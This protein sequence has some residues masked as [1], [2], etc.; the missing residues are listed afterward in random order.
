[1]SFGP[2]PS[3][4]ARVDGFFS[5][6]LSAVSQLPVTSLRKPVI[7]TDGG[8]V[9]RLRSGVALCREPRVFLRRI[10]GS[11]SVFGYFWPGGHGVKIWGPPL[12]VPWHLIQSQDT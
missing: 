9:L 2:S 7:E 5:A 10:L 4:L 12:S 11:C 6:W 8:S 1:M 3:R